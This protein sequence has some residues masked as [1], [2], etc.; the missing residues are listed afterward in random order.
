[1]LRKQ[2]QFSSFLHIERFYVK[3]NLHFAKSERRGMIR[4]SPHKIGA[5]KCRENAANRSYAVEY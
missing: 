4:E 5:K 3:R 2:H 1:M